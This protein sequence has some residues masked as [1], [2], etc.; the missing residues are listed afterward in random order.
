[1]QIPSPAISQFMGGYLASIFGRLLSI[2]YL[3]C[4]SLWA[5]GVQQNTC[6]FPVPQPTRSFLMWAKIPHP[7]SRIV[8]DMGL[9]LGKLEG[10]CSPANIWSWNHVLPCFPIHIHVMWWK[11]GNSTSNCDISRLHRN[12]NRSLGF[13]RR[14]VL[15][16]VHNLSLLF[17][18]GELD[19]QLSLCV[20]VAPASD[21]LDCN[22]SSL[23]FHQSVRVMSLVSSHCR[24]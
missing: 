22:F 1:L 11:I 4:I 10:L 12:K 16:G 13:M 20:W 24:N 23:V 9:G 2:H 3:L 18:D 7:Q 5:I 14:T 8:Q 19:Y 21:L 15:K 6:E 17:M